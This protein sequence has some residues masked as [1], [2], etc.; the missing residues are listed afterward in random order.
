MKTFLA[1]FAFTVV[2]TASMASK[3]GG[4]SSP[5]E[6][7]VIPRELVVRKLQ[8]RQ[9]YRFLPQSRDHK[10]ADEV[11]CA[12]DLCDKGCKKNGFISGKCDK[13]TCIGTKCHCLCDQYH[14]L[15]SLF[16]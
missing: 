1:L 4:N 6:D 3:L 9:I 16:P 7:K 13:P 5:M 10:L 2:F 14:I 11:A 15:W 8:K 12:N